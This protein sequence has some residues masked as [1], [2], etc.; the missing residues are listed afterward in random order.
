MVYFMYIMLIL[1]KNCADLNSKPHGGI[2]L[3]QKLL[4]MVG[5]RFYPPI[6]STHFELLEL[7]KYKIGT[8]RGSFLLENHQDANVE[9]KK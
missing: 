1:Q 2:L 5:A 7:G 6:D 4:W 9:I 3:M 8:H